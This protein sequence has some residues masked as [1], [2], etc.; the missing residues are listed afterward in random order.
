MMPLSGH[1][2]SSAELLGGYA[3]L[4]LILD[5]RAPPPQT[6]RRRG[7]DQPEAPRLPLFKLR[8]MLS[9]YDANV[10]VAS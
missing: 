10:T 8:L 4:P 1:G 5:D 3:T 2:L 7:W 6:E 9:L